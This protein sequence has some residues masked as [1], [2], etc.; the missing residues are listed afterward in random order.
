MSLKKETK[1]I[2]K[3]KI[4]RSFDGCK[5]S[6][7]FFKSKNKKAKTLVL[8][9]GVGS[10]C[11][12]WKK[13]LELFLEKGHSIINIDLRGHGQSSSPKEF[14]RYQLPHFS[15]DIHEV[16]NNEKIK[17]FIF[18]GHSFGG[19]I[20][21]NYIMRY[22][23]KFPSSI[24]FIESSSTYP[25]DHNRILNLNPYVTNLLRFI[26]KH[27]ITNSEHFFH[28]DDI[29]LSP[30]GIKKDLKRLSHLMHFTPIRS[31]V[32][33]L[34]NVEKFAFANRKN[35]KKTLMNLDIPV[36]VIAG[37][38]DKTIPKEYSERI[39][40]LVKKSEMKTFEYATHNILVEKPE[41][42]STEIC[43][44]ISNHLK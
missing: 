22:K 15:R 31:I 39:N 5:I 9:H 42:I 19:V 43:D 34:D 35:I 13:E 16:L 33:T 36:L 41:E 1:D 38:R 25:F 3:T 28:M 32:R 2:D 10:D 12:V 14:E 29:D 23:R 40:R 4:I 27:Q 37:G 18:V 20:A 8:L 7:E 24:I 21:L 30:S 26:A 6:Y 44:F 17:D 11:K